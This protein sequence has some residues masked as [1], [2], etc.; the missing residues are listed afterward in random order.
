MLSDLHIGEVVSEAETGGI[1]RYDMTIFRYRLE[2]LAH[3]IHKLVRAHQP[4]VVKLNVACLGDNISG[5]IHE[6][7]AETNDGNS[8][9]MML[10]ASHLLA[11]FLLDMLHTFE[12]IET[13]WITGNHGRTGKRYR[14]KQR[15]LNWDYVIAQHV[16]ALLRNE[17]RIKFTIPR[18]FWTI[19]EIRGHRILAIHG[20]Q[21]RS[22]Q[23]IPFYGMQRA[24]AELQALLKRGGG[25]DVMVMGHF[26]N[27][28]M[29]DRAGD[30]ELIVNGSMKGA[31][32]FSLGAIFQGTGPK[33]LFMGVHPRP[34]IRIS[35]RY[36]LVLTNAPEGQ[37]FRYAWDREF[38]E[39][40]LEVLP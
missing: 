8:V 15:Y 14:F 40:S 5:M 21:I 38:P 37:P 13:W 31:D 20:D 7:L 33:Q 30:L 34:D 6:E 12:E 24:M 23:S 1:G 19:M 26:H 18:S 29:L 17:K 25:F 9:D 35:F 16:R 22:W 11:Q 2:Y 28:G 36:P 4:H 10:A 3:K 39:S 27:V 32:E